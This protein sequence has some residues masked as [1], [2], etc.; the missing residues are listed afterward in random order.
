MKSQ[1]VL[2]L[3]A[4][5]LTFVSGLAIS[6]PNKTQAD[7]KATNPVVMT[8]SAYAQ[9]I[10]T[11]AERA[12]LRQLSAQKRQATLAQSGKTTASQFKPTAAKNVKTYEVKSTSAYS[13]P[14]KNK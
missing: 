9:P 2:I 3:S 11:R 5:S 13:Q 10:Q 6:V 12:Q 8:T 4:L 1:A 14:I 7:T